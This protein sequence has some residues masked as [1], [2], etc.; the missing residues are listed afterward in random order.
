ME[1]QK[2]RR[3]TDG[4]V[5]EKYIMIV[6]ELLGIQPENERQNP[7]GREEN[8]VEE[9]EVAVAQGNHVGNFGLRIADC[10]FWEENGKTSF[11][12]EF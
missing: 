10:G 5:N 12:V 7:D 11:S 1:D 6:N 9:E 2:T 4:Y 3:Y 8:E